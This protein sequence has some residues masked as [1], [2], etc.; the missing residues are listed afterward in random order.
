[1]WVYRY[2]DD[3][4]EDLFAYDLRRYYATDAVVEEEESPSAGV[5]RDGGFSHEATSASGSGASDGKKAD[6]ALE[7]QKVCLCASVGGWA[8]VCVCVYNKYIYIYIAIYLSIYIY[9]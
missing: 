2:D 3:D 4:E 9:I 5:T 6:M 7:K 8:N 1:M